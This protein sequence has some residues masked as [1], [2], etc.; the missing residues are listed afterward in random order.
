MCHNKFIHYKNVTCSKKCGRAWSHRTEL[1][2][3][4]SRDTAIRIALDPLYSK[5]LKTIR[6]EFLFNEVLIRCDSKVEYACLDY[7]IK[8]YNVVSLKRCNFV[9]PFTFEGNVRHYVPDFK[10]IDVDGK[11]Y[12]VEAKC[13]FITHHLRKK[14]RYYYETIPFKREAL[15]AYCSVNGYTSVYFDRSMHRRFYDSVKPQLLH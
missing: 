1:R 9:I 7:L 15:N 4:Q 10:M 13:E 8:T 2:E 6:C 14:W 3:K 12:I 11:T 5:R